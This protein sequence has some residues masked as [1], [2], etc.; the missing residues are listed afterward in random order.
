MHTDDSL[1]DKEGTRQKKN[2]VAAGDGEDGD[3]GI[4]GRLGG[5]RRNND[6]TGTHNTRAI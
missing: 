3:G 1:E 6:N 2:L 5:W 4:G